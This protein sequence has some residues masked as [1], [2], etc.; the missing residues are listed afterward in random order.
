M[1]IERNVDTTTDTDTLIIHYYLSFKRFR[2]QKQ[3]PLRC[4][5]LVIFFMFQKI[6]VNSVFLN[7]FLTSN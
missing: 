2:F 5:L 7:C 4:F 1:K 6:L 3:K